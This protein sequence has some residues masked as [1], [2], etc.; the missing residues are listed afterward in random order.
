MAQLLVLDAVDPT[1]NADE[2]NENIS[3]GSID[4]DDD[5]QSGPVRE[6]DRIP[7]EWVQRAEACMDAKGVSFEDACLLVRGFKPEDCSNQMFKAH[8]TE[9]HTIRLLESIRADEK[10]LNALKE[11][12]SKHPATG[13]CQQG[14]PQYES[15]GSFKFSRAHPFWCGP[16]KKTFHINI[17]AQRLVAAVKGP[18]EDLWKLPLNVA[19]NEAFREFQVSH[20][21]SHVPVNRC[22][23]PGHFLLENTVANL[24]RQGCATG[25]RKCECQPACIKGPR[26]VERDESRDESRETSKPAT[27]PPYRGAP[28]NN[29]VSFATEGQLDVLHHI[30]DDTVRLDDQ[31][32]IAHLKFSITCCTAIAQFWSE[33]NSNVDRAAARAVCATT[34]RMINALVNN[35]SA[36]QRQELLDSSDETLPQ[37]LQNVRCRKFSCKGLAASYW[38]AG[39]PFFRRG[40]SFDWVKMLKFLDKTTKISTMRGV[41]AAICAAIGIVLWQ[42]QWLAILWSDEGQSNRSGEVLADDLDE[43][44]DAMIDSPTSS[45]VESDEGSD[46]DI[47]DFVSP[48]GSAAI[49]DGSTAES[50]GVADAGEMSD[51]EMEEISSVVGS[52]AGIEAAMSGEQLRRYRQCVTESDQMNFLH[53]EGLDGGS[54]MV[55]DAAASDSDL[56]FGG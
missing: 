35:A 56:S 28:F 47:E 43:Q 1:G 17:G 13:P 4:S 34:Y 3:G 52:E 25:R 24:R 55:D 38:I 37:Q 16:C 12:E 10:Y 30:R 41:V 36:N 48:D 29:S 20:L 15:L 18:P 8:S 39:D 21:C 51:E 19:S 44:L 46:P 2:T 54:G 6:N 45:T 32:I 42:A 5:S 23:V 31:N 14:E 53:Y 22:I 40:N 7:K 50:E 49:Q 27:R 26:F 9:Y 11:M 33:P